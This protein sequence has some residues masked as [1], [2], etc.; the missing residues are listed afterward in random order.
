MYAPKFIVFILVIIQI[1]FRP[2]IAASC[3]GVS[4]NCTKPH[5]PQPM[6]KNYGTISQRQLAKIE[7][8]ANKITIPDIVQQDNTSS[9]SSSNGNDD[10]DFRFLVTGGY[11]PQNNQLIK[12]VVS[13]RLKNELL[14]FGDNHFCG[15]SIISPNSIL[16][17]AH[18]LYLRY[19]RK[20]RPSEVRVYTGTPRRLVKTGNTQ[21]LRVDKVKPHFKYSPKKL[22]SDIGI[23][24]LKDTVRTD[25]FSAIIPIID[26]NSEAG[27]LCTVVGWGVIIENG[28]IPDEAV[29][30]DLSI[31]SK[32]WCS[33]YVVGFAK[34]MLCASNTNNY[35]VDSCQGDSGGP[36]I[37]NGKVV[38]IVS[39]GLG[40]GTPN[41]AGVYSD[42]YSFR[43]WIERNAG[44]KLYPNNGFPSFSHMLLM[45]MIATVY[46]CKYI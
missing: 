7:D 41:S 40:C 31:H 25:S 45:I 11:R 17:A 36:L 22:S 24:R 39:F 37:T 43:N 16:T 32:S 4:W 27:M 10:N 21:E 35:E 15:G 6:A 9:N 29:S 46:V 42:V 30:G 34:S 14:F 44:S 3:G 2:K 26:R 12:F 8:S 1:C 13:L 33:K 20:L 19:S 38:G 28:P 18:C 23:L 5:N